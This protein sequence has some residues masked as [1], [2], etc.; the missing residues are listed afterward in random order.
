ML[1]KLIFD[2]VMV[3]KLCIWD[4][5]NIIVMQEMKRYR[6]DGK[7]NLKALDVLLDKAE[8]LYDAGYIPIFQFE[9]S[10]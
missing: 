6:K 2:K 10:K 4:G 5:D 8:E 3:I 1:I 9:R 7:R